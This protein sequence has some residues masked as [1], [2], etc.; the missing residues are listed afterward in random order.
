MIHMPEPL[1]APPRGQRWTLLWDSERLEYGGTSAAAPLRRMAGTSQKKQY[2]CLLQTRL[3]DSGLRPG[4]G[5]I[6]LPIT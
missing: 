1:L 3:Y 5:N 2:F 6:S 4:K